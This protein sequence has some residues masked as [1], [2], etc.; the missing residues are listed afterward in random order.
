M[1]APAADAAPVTGP[2]P[3]LEPLGTRIDLDDVTKRYRMGGAGVLALDRVDL[4]VDETAFVVILGPSGS[5]KT[6]LLNMI[7]LLDS[8]SEGRVGLAGR[9]VTH[10]SRRDRFGL[11]RTR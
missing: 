10:V 11:R 2:R 4:H 6:T 8:P 5:G 9:D 3:M 1:S 7:G